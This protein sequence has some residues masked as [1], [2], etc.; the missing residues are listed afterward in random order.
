LVTGPS[1]S[2]HGT[3]FTNPSLLLGAPQVD[4]LRAFFN[5][6]LF[7]TATS[8]RVRDALQSVPPDAQQNVRIVYTAHSIPLAMANTSD[9][10]RQLEEVRRLVWEKTGGY[11]RH[12]R[13][14]KSQRI[15]RPA[16]AGTRHS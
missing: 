12:P 1:D 9:Y 15:P 14:S 8:E 13:V 4:K 16:L 3:F 11:E 2:N 7:I 10:V 5:H 6:P